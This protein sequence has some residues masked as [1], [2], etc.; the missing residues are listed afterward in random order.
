MTTTTHRYDDPIYALGRSDA[1]YDRLMLQAKA[2]APLTRRFL[3]EAGLTPGM[4][5]IDVGCG[6]GDLSM[7]AAEIVGP[8]GSVVGVDLDADALEIAR[9]RARAAG[10][11][12]L[13][14][15]TGDLR[16]VALESGADAVIG[17][18]VLMYLA[19]PV[20]GIVRATRLVR[21][22]GIVAFLEL[23]LATPPISDPPVADWDTMIG[24]INSTLAAMGCE[25]EMAR[26]LPRVFHRAGL[27]PVGTFGSFVV[28]GSAG[29][30]GLEEWASQTLRSLHPMAKASGLLPPRADD[31]DAF[32]DR[33]QLALRHVDGFVW[34]PPFLGVHARTR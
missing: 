17:R 16:D 13:S 2:I 27:N 23:D 8:T 19:D 7:L 34:S 5:V 22:G 21:T 24:V 15:E 12:R 20:E 4:R 26:K 25:T 32:V 18:L 10:L 1:E 3:Y 11:H 9:R 33:V 31:I 14:F 29:Q 28:G 6:V 30:D